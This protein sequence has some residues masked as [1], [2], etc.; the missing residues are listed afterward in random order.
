MPRHWLAAHRS[1]PSRPPS[2]LYERDDWRQ[3]VRAHRL[4]GTRNPHSR[5]EADGSVQHVFGLPARF[6]PASV[7]G[8]ACAPRRQ[9]KNALRYAK[10]FTVYAKSPRAPGRRG[11]CGA[12]LTWL[13]SP[14]SPR[15]YLPTPLVTWRCPP[16]DVD[17]PAGRG[18]LFLWGG[19]R[20]RAAVWKGEERR[21]L[22][23][24]PPE[25]CRP[26]RG[27]RRLRGDHRAVR[28]A[29]IATAAPVTGAQS[30]G[31]GDASTSGLPTA[32][33]PP[34]KPLESRRPRHSKPAQGAG[35]HTGRAGKDWRSDNPNLT[36]SASICKNILATGEP[37]H[38]PTASGPNRTETMRDETLGP[39]VGIPPG[40][41][42][43]GRALAPLTGRR[44]TTAPM[45][46]AQAARP[47]SWEPVRRGAALSACKRAAPALGLPRR[48]LDLLDYL[49]GRTVEAGS[50]AT[51]RS[52][53]PRTP[54]CRTRSGSGAP[55]SRPWSA[56]PWSAASSRWPTA[57]TGSATADASRGA[58]S[59]R[60][61]ST[62]RRWPPGTPSSWRSPRRTRSGAGRGGGCAPGSHRCA[63]RSSRSPTPPRN[64]SGRAEGRT[65]RPWRPRRAGSQAG[66]GT[67]TIPA[68]S[69]PLSCDFE[70]LH[71]EVQAALTQAK[72]NTVHFSCLC[73]RENQGE[74][75][76][77]NWLVFGR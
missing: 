36:P 15:G 16:Q 5:P 45:L 58:W 71:A 18:S 59:R 74:C 7:H 44:K 76:I 23:R 38:V 62:S 4:V 55:R 43:A 60:T 40:R 57:R 41:Q 34:R 77:F 51:A 56:P 24:N 64:W 69:R 12:R 14:K 28:H 65:G 17:W 48:V 67:A 53:G 73:R 50:T 21:S 13:R 42:P 66:G 3:F 68:S 26:R 27:V 47:A 31:R 2:R 1:T 70:A 39:S 54:P 25:I 10:R 29:L 33:G 75:C 32:A 30:C 61:V 52:P 6:P 49:V 37:C 35:P 72:P 11:A 9:T 46:A 63:T 8:N 19:G 22:L 20:D